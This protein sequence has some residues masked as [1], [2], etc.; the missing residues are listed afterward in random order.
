MNHEMLYWFGYRVF[1]KE[2]DIQARHK[3]LSKPFKTR[4]EAKK[5]RITYDSKEFEKTA[6][7]IAKDKNAAEIELK[8][9]DFNRL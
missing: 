9:E 2:I 7:F 6:I 1:N 5:D 4:D 8:K 3:V